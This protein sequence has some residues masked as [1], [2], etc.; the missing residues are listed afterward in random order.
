VLTSNDISNPTI[1]NVSDAVISIRRSKL[2][3]PTRIGN[4]G[5]FFKNP[6]VSSEEFNLIKDKYSLIPSY[7]GEN[8][9]VKIPAA[10]MIEECG[11][12]GETRGSI[13]VH[14]E[15]ALVL[16]N[17][18]NGKGIDIWNLSKEIQDNVYKKFQILLHPE[19]NIVHD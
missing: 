4:A 1:K 12:K 17:Y 16:V 14:K 6:S 3:D 13:G 7:P 11:Y 2:P 10:W 19:V 5:S 15:Q 18:G 8:G 9:L